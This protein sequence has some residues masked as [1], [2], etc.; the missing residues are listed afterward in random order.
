M[1]SVACPFIRRGA[2]GLVTFYGLP[3][4]REDMLH[5]IGSRFGSWRQPGVYGYGNGDAGAGDWR[6]HRDLHPGS[7]PDDEVAAVAEPERI[8]RVVTATIVASW[9]VCRATTPST[10]ILCT[11]ICG[12]YAGIRRDGGLSGQ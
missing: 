3:S 5:D 9:V 2:N 4:I 6:Q 10:R 12:P 8:F 7:R 1:H 11:P